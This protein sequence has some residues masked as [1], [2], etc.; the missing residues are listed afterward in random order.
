MK[1]CDRPGCPGPKGLCLERLDNEH[2]K[3]EYYL[4]TLSGH[5]KKCLSCGNISLIVSGL[6]KTCLNCGETSGGCG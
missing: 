1:I 6:C 5:L 3:C 2:H 4:E